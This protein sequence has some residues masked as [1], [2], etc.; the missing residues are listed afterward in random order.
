M[1][2]SRIEKIR[3]SISIA[4]SLI[5]LGWTFTAYQIS[6]WGWYGTIISLHHLAKKGRGAVPLAL[7]WATGIVWIA[8]YQYSQPV[9]FLWRNARYWAASLIFLWIF[10]I[11]LILT[12]AKIPTNFRV[13]DKQSQWIWWGSS[14]LMTSCLGLGFCCYQLGLELH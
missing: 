11:S 9:G 1:V 8:A 7:A 5:F 12:V 4:L 10:S 14:I 6:L 2:F 13:R 3:T